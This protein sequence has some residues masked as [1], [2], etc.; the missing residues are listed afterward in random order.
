MGEPDAFECSGRA[1]GLSGFY[2]AAA[3]WLYIEAW[4]YFQ[5]CQWAWLQLV[6]DPVLIITRRN[7]QGSNLSIDLWPAAAL[8]RMYTM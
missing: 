4:F 2:A 6:D 5:R 8:F 7:T 1:A 3:R